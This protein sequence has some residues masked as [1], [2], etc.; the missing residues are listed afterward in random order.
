MMHPAFYWSSGIVT[1]A[2][3]MD[4]R[5][6]EFA[7]AMPLELRVHLDADELHK[8]LPRSAF[9]EI[10]SDVCRRADRVNLEQYASSAWIGCGGDT[11]LVAMVRNLSPM[12]DE[13]V[14]RS[15][16]IEEVVKL[17]QMSEMF[18]VAE[19]MGA[20]LWVHGLGQQGLVLT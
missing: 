7:F 3:Y 16:L 10:S 8:P 4:R 9:P 1:G 14:D 19:A 6:L 20:V 15:A 13:V 2:P 5:V 12:F 11:D 17:R 18:K